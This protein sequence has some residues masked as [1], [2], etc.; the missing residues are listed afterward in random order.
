MR[1]SFHGKDRSGGQ[2]VLEPLYLDS[3]SALTPQH[4]TTGES[5]DQHLQKVSQGHHWFPVSGRFHKISH[6]SQAAISLLHS[7]PQL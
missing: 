3:K 6:L 5:P 4:L 1:T 7:L 2:N